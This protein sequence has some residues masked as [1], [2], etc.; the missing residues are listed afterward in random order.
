VVVLVERGWKLYH[1]EIS[2]CGSTNICILAVWRNCIFNVTRVMSELVKFVCL[3][4]IWQC[5]NNWCLNWSEWVWVCR[6]ELLAPQT[7]CLSQWKEWLTVN[8][9]LD[10]M[11]VCMLCGPIGRL[12]ESRLLHGRLQ[13]GRKYLSASG[14]PINPFDW[15]GLADNAPI[16]YK[17]V[18]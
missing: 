15:H 5:P 7:W 17:Q 2:H 12:R 11:S 10:S 4:L 9:D 6:V 13:D 16:G 14:K 3:L 8:Y 18:N 1:Y